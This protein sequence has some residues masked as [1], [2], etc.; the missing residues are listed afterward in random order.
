MAALPQCDDGAQEELAEARRRRRAVPV[1]ERP[2]VPTQHIDRLRREPRSCWAH[3]AVLAWHRYPMATPAVHFSKPVSVTKQ[4]RL[5]GPAV[6]DDARCHEQD[7]TIHFGHLLLLSRRPARVSREHSARQADP[8]G[9]PQIF[10]PTTQHR[11]VSSASRS[12]VHPPF[13]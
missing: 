4:A 11:T 8:A 3:A 10:E 12:A 13:R 5:D 7:F 6:C 2:D 1:L 9:H